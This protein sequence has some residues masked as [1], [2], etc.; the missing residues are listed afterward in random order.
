MNQAYKKLCDLRV[1]A[2]LFDMDVDIETWSLVPKVDRTEPD[3]L[4]RWKDKRDQGDFDE[5]FDVDQE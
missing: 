2:M 5:R 1:Q 4:L 3:W